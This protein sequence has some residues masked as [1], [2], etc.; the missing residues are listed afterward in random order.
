MPFSWPS[1]AVATGEKGK[2]S[3]EYTNYRYSAGE[4][5]A[6][7]VGRGGAGLRGKSLGNSISMAALVPPVE[8]ESINSLSR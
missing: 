2:Y 1:A 6:K 7:S 4:E 5:I 8:G 3:Y